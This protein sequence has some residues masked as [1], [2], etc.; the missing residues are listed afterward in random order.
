[1]KRFL[2]FLLINVFN[3]KIKGGIP[4]GIKKAVI[5][6]AP[7]TSLWDFVIGLIAFWYLQAN[8][9]FMIK[10]EAFT[11]PFGYFM[12]KLGGVPVKRGKPA[13]LL[14]QILRM[15]QDNEEFF[16]VITPEGTRALVENWKKGFY[17]IAIKTK[18]PIILAFIDYKEKK[19]GLGPVFYPTGNFEKDIVEIEKFYKPFHGKHPKQFNLYQKEVIDQNNS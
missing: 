9:K 11:W 16:T 15:Y 18:V 4:D 2:I 19:G 14:I 5:I 3:W 1:M 7:H 13:H 12:R 10:S 6:V 17:Q 8:V